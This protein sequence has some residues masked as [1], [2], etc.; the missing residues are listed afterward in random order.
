MTTPTPRARPVQW[1]EHDTPTEHVPTHLIVGH[2]TDPE[3]T[4]GWPHAEAVA[5]HDH[6]HS[7]GG[8]IDHLIQD[9]GR[10]FR[11][12]RDHSSRSRYGLHAVLHAHGLSHEPKVTAEPAST[13]EHSHEGYWPRGEEA[14]LHLVNAHGWGSAEVLSHTL[15]GAEL[16]HHSAHQ[17]VPESQT[18]I[19]RLRTRDTHPVN[20]LVHHTPTLA[21]E[22]T[23]TRLRMT[24]QY[25]AELLDHLREVEDR[26]GGTW[27]LLDDDG[28]EAV[29]DHLARVREAEGDEQYVAA[30]PLASDIDKLLG[31]TQ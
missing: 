10:V 21:S 17:P 24:S 18:F 22:D 3:E 30:V 16:E 8:R 20:V 11:D 4:G 28:I 6:L 14:R 12:V 23:E 7:L 27:V 13:V 15:T 2:G 19:K 26:L 31:V 29:L 1:H 25:H 5:L 9:H